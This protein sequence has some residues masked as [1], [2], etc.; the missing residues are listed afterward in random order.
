MG[1]AQRKSIMEIGRTPAATPAQ[2][3]PRS[4]AAAPQRV[5]DGD[6]DDG[7]KSSARPPSGTTATLG[8]KINT[9]A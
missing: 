3:T 7:A 4:N 8:T 1:P 6:A 2:Y 5:N 9:T